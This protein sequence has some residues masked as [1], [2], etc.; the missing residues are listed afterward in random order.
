MLL[1]MD[2]KFIDDG[3]ALLNGSLPDDIRVMGIKR[4]VNFKRDSIFY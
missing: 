2:Q 4:T 3:P 1:P